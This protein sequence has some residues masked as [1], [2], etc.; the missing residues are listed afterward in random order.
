MSIVKN[1]CGINGFKKRN[2]KYKSKEKTHVLSREML[3]WDTIVQWDLESCTIIQSYKTMLIFFFL[4]L[5]LTD[6]ISMVDSIGSFDCSFIIEIPMKEWMLFHLIDFDRREITE[7]MQCLTSVDIRGG[8]ECL[9]LLSLSL[10]LY[11]CFAFTFGLTRAFYLR[12]CV[13]W[14]AISF[15]V[16]PF[17]FTFLFFS[18]SFSTFCRIALPSIY[19]IVHLFSLSIDLL[20]CL[21]IQT[22]WFSR[23]M[24]PSKDTSRL[25]IL[26][27]WFTSSWIY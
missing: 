23:K 4:S 8:D 7:L 16:N 9:F 15:L 10:S 24:N 14:E 26:M 22:D 27:S 17:S 5:K 25:N 18:L 20:A 12:T 1:W 21:F 11:L 19:T 13:S 3:P 2:E 6:E